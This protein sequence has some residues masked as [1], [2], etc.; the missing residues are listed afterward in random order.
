MRFHDYADSQTIA[1][2]R[3]PIT[4][5]TEAALRELEACLSPST[6]GVKP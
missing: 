5:V 6:S 1:R 3:A 4:R 2:L